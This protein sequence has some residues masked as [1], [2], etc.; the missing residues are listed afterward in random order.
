MPIV[1]TPTVGEA[2]QRFSQI[3]RDMRGIWLKGRIPERLRNFPYQDI[4]LIVVT[5]NERILG[6]GDHGAGAWAS[7]RGLVAGVSQVFPRAVVQ[8]EDFHKRKQG[9]LF[10][11]TSE[12]R[13]VS[14]RI[15]AA[16]VR[17]A[18]ARQLGLQVTEADVD[19]LVADSIWFPEYVP[20]RSTDPV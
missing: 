10:P 7:P 6:L 4:R 17:H 20:V 5:D 1:Y 8:W 14:A 2:C 13:G 16:I 18:S 11:D 9:A 3:V 12:L 19:A 15:A